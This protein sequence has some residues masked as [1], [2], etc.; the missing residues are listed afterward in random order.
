[1]PIFLRYFR[2]YYLGFL[3]VSK[4]YKKLPDGGISIPSGE[5]MESSLGSVSNF[6]SV[7]VPHECFTSKCGPSP[8]KSDL[9]WTIKPR[10]N[11]EDAPTSM[12]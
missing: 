2:I 1:M 6:N 12:S 11:T 4:I 7:K 8:C 10:F 3:H 5:I 9:V